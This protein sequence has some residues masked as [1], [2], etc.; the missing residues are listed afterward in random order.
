MVDR[1]D[2]TKKWCKRNQKEK[3]E[4]KRINACLFKKNAFLC[5][6]EVILKSARDFY[7]KFLLHAQSSIDVNARRSNL[8]FLLIITAQ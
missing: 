3:E 4:I 1:K 2:K 6:R 8:S 7:Y 5:V